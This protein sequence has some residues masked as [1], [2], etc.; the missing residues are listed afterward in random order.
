[1][2]FIGDGAEKELLQQLTKE[3][4]LENKVWFIGLI[5][6]VEVV[7]WLQNSRASFVTFMDLPVLH[8]NSPNKMF[9]SFAAG[10]PIIQST[11]GWIADLV[12]VYRC[13]ITVDP[14][15][16]Q[17]IA[18]AIRLLIEQ[19]DVAKEMGE[20]ALDLA[21]TEFNRDI[22][23]KKFLEGIKQTQN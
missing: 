10:I 7:K 9:D 4:G 21:M 18:S 3:Y 15:Q 8:T 1:M 5:P 19:P 2:V 6:K 12:R 20:N 16:P 11:R 17:E 22:L 13:G 14:N 23:S